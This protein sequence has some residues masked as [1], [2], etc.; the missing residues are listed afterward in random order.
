M[1]IIA[2]SASSLHLFFSFRSRSISQCKFSSTSSSLLLLH[3][4]PFSKGLQFATHWLQWESLLYFYHREFKP[5]CPAVWKP[6]TSYHIAMLLISALCISCL[7]FPLWDFILR[8]LVQ[9]SSVAHSC[10][11]LCDPMDCST[12]SCSLN[13]RLTITLTIPDHH[14]L[15]ELLKF[16]SIESVMPSN[17]LILCCPLLLPSSIFPGI[18]VFTNE[19]VFGNRWPKYCSFSISP[20]NENS[21]LISF[22]MDW[23]DFLSV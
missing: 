21:G 10:P 22:R 5:Q 23:F 17:H 8:C 9:F 3:Q 1:L 20:S 12:A 11:T 15:L 19:S 14:Q 13:G 16:M 7:I 6:L 18:R 4:S 2:S